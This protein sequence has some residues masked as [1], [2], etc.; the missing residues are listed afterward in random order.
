MTQSNTTLPP[1]SDDLF[2]TD[3]GLETTL[4]FLEGYELPSFAAFE[5]L[6]N[7]EG[8]K[9]IHD[10]YLR[11]LNIAREFR[12]GFILESPTWR[13][14]PDWIKILDYPDSAIEEINQ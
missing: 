6:K 12:T 7:E 10:Y 9:A 5:L 14:N 13:A 11:Y 2:L 8:Y 3:G 1:H 4:I